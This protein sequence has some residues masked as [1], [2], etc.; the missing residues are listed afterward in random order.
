MALIQIVDFG[1]TLVK[2][3]TY[4]I[5]LG[6]EYP[7][8]NLLIIGLSATAIRT[9]NERFHSFM[10]VLLT[11]FQLLWIVRHFNRVG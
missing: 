2:G 6:P 11:S 10:V 7:I 9:R 1:D 8:R 5:G 4:F 3:W